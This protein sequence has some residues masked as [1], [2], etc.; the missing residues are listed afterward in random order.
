MPWFIGPVECVGE[1]RLLRDRDAVFGHLVHGLGRRHYR[2][3]IEEV[4]LILF[5]RFVQYGCQFIDRQLDRGIADCV[6][7][8]LPSHCM[9]FAQY[10]LEILECHPQRA[11]IFRFAFVGFLRVRRRAG[12][13]S[14]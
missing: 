6:D 11:A 8:E 5:R 4:P 13:A 14:V 3:V 12:E 7:A 10:L 1:I 2:E 9:S